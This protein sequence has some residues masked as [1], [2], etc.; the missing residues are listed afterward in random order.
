MNAGLGP[1]SMCQPDRE[2]KGGA[3]TVSFRIHLR[4]ADT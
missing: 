1:T 3:A 4:F 2:M